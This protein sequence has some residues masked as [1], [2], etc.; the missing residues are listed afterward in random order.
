MEV[1]EFRNNLGKTPLALAIENDQND[2]AKY[3]IETYPEI[4]FERKDS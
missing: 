3:L 2:I 1:V 4:N